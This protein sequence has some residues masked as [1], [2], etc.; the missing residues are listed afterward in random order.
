MLRR[1]PCRRSQA[2]KILAVRANHRPVDQKGGP[3]IQAL[4]ET[5]QAPPVTIRV[6]SV[7]MRL[8][9]MVEWIGDLNCCYLKMPKQNLP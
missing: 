9:R 7:V 3:V 2:A 4:E 1:F 5:G 6:A 8:P